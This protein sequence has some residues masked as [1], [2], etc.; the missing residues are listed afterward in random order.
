MNCPVKKLL[1]SFLTA[2]GVISSLYM[3]TYFIL[4]VKCFL[5][6]SGFSGLWVLWY[7]EIRTGANI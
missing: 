2:S 5:S 1:R 7:L 3:I 4:E 6:E